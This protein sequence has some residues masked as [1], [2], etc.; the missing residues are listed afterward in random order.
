MIKHKEN[1]LI[2]N[3][4]Q[5]VILIS[6]SNEFKNRF[7]Q[8]AVPFKIY[9]DFEC[10]LKGVKSSDKS[11]TSYTE[12]YQDHIPCSFVYNV[13]YVDNK[14]SKRVVLY[15]GK[16]QFIDSLKQSLKNIIIVKK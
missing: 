12:K 5:S 10:L 8:L 2:I 13:V 6:D 11:N 4:K 7:K 14:F 3:G 9:A 1:C 15:R 16:M